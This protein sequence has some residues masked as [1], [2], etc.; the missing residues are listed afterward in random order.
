[1]LRPLLLLSMLA[2][3]ACAKTGVPQTGDTPLPYHQR[4]IE[5]YQDR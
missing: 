3:G 1:M 4:F 2:L 5:F